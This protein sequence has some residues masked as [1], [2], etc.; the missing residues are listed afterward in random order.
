MSGSS[1][2]LDDFLSSPSGQTAD[3]EV[4]TNGVHTK[5]DQDTTVETTKQLN[6]DED[7]E[8]ADEV[9]READEHTDVNSSKDSSSTLRQDLKST[10]DD[11][12]ERTEEQVEERQPKETHIRE[13]M[14]DRTSE[15]STQNGDS[16]SVDAEDTDLEGKT[17]D[18]ESDDEVEQPPKL[19]YTRLTGLPTRF[20]DKDPV[21][22]CIFNERAFI[23]ASHSGIIHLCRPDFSPIRTLKAHMTSIL[24]LDTDGEYFASGSMDGTVVIG[25]I[26][27]ESDITR[28]DFKRP[29]YAVALDKKYR[30]SRAFFSGGTSGKLTRSMK[31]WLGQRQDTVFGEDNGP[32]TM[33]KTI[34]DLLFW[35]NDGGIHIAQIS[36]KAALLDV[37]LPEDFPR[38]EVYWP[39]VHIIDRD[40]ILLAWVNHIWVFRINVTRA[41][42]SST[43]NILSSAASS[44]ISPIEEK[45]IEIERHTSLE[46]MLIAGVS[47]FNDNL[48]V[49]NY[50][51]P[52]STRDEKTGRKVLSGQ[53]PELV[54]VNRVTLDEESVDEV[55]LNRFSSLGL[56]DY[57]L[58]Q[59]VSQSE[60]PKWY[61]ISANDG[62]VVQEFSLR[63]RL[64]W[65]T[66]K[67]RYL[68]AWNMSAL[69]LDKIERLDI[70][71]RQA[72]EYVSEDQWS[73]A[74]EFLGE[75]FKVTSE[76]SPAYLERICREW[77]SWL[78]I[79]LDAGH[80]KQIVDVLPC[81][82]LGPDGGIDPK[83]YALSF[84]CFLSK[85]EYDHVIEFVTKWDHRLFDVDELAYKIG[86]V[87][88]E[89]DEKFPVD[90]D[91]TITDN[92]RYVGLRETY[93]ALRVELDEPEKCVDHL[94]KL[95]D[96]EIMQFLDEHH[97]IHQNMNKLPIIMRIAA[98]ED[99]LKRKRIPK[100]REELSV[101]I[102]ILV[103]SSHEILPGRITD[104][105]DNAG[106]NFVSYLYLEKLSREDKLLVRDLEDEM[107]ELYALY[108]RDE[109]SE[110]LGKHKNYSIEKAIKVCEQT[111]CIPELA[112]LLSKVGENKKALTLIIDDLEDPQ[113]AIRFVESAN[114]KELWDFL[115]DYSM[116]RPD[117]IRALLEASGDLIDPIPVVDRIPKGIEI[118]GLRD[119]LI[120]ITKNM[121]L[122]DWMYKIILQIIWK[123]TVA[124]SD[125]YRDLRLQGYCYGALNNRVRSTM[126][127]LIQM[128]GDT[129]QPLVSEGEVLGENNVWNGEASDP[130]G[131]IKHASFIKGRLLFQR[132]GENSA[133]ELN[134]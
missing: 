68:E 41:T 62:V 97:L 31:G 85:K 3:E 134:H 27:N 88:K 8:A 127:T 89:G 67:G 119:A 36:S 70:G 32:I 44:F 82:P 23:F 76:E 49:L 21:S 26:E 98:D 72:N 94:I 5:N 84:D 17:N 53:P 103:E 65:L 57:H 63:D 128:P 47:E 95:R 50:I 19:K 11:A 69:W 118:K 105:M 66:A 33:I 126:Q 73:E 113:M 130:V 45:E 124:T 132:T 40:R 79:F 121:V 35:T 30:S 117:F 52:Q 129:N 56:N 104:V 42:R 1:R 102:S 10:A 22:A 39:R 99:D 20:F 60:G 123:D 110:F 115:L 116:D 133:R 87:L 37:P 7:N 51:P 112:Y 81:N 86:E 125:K 46:D 111:H 64:N 43:S 122:D 75:V 29:I 2:I 109:L 48:L 28:Y 18:S 106:M 92:D 107:V 91:M 114:D 96:K 80:I 58:H 100:L 61:L 131:K 38:P 83:F 14:E 120:K 101:N 25:S 93:V 77:N 71:I 90:T 54:I 74:A 78:Q 9:D 13:V 12:I 24:S 15:D 4:Q 6:H 16:V 34:D 59:Y 55:A 108:N